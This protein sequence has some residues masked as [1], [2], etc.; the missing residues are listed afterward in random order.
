MAALRLEEFSS[1]MES[2]V[3][4]LKLMM[5]VIRFRNICVSIIVMMEIKVK[6]TKRSE[7]ESR[8][9]VSDQTCKF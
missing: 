5:R 3:K 6:D 2:N 4:E 7:E 9:N 1:Q 8:Q